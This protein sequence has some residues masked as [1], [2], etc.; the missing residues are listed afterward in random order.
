MKKKYERP[1]MEIQ[2]FDVEDT[3]TVSSAPGA[4]KTLD[5]VNT[6]YQSPVFSLR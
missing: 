3:I 4:P 5:N 1:R 6:Q 2:R